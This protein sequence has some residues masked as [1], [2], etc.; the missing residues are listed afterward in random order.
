M[1]TTGSIRRTRW[2]TTSGADPNAD[3]QVFL[4]PHAGGTAP[5]YQAWGATL[6]SSMEVRT[7][8]LPGRQE[9]FDEQP[10]T[11]VE[12]LLDALQ[13]AFEAEL[14]GR[15]YV[16]FGH[17]FGGMLAY[18]LSVAAAWNGLP[19]PELLAV[20]SWAPGLGWAAELAQVATMSDGELLARVAELGLLTE[21]TSLD[22]ATLASIMPAI[23]ADFLAAGSL[24]EDGEPAPCPVAAYGG[25]SDPIVPPGSLSV[26]AEHTT[27]FL[28]TTQSP[29]GHFHLFDDAAAV[30]YS[31]ERQVRKLR[32]RG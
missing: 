6:P 7:L 12:P 2:F 30:Q 17:S 11:D 23:R 20:S 15:P 28:G 3:V 13:E 10:F 9:R 22:A 27:D 4:F 24:D 29:S 1:T 32:A 18:R 19:E 26:W 25:E 14:D 21:G 5:A 8:Q 31:L 16:L